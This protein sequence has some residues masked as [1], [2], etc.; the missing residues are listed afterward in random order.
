MPG[1]RWSGGLHQAIEAKEGVEVKPESI[2]LASITFQNLF[3]MYKKLAGMTGTALTSAEEFD[4]VY[5][6]DVVPI[7]TNKPIIRVDLSDRVY[8]TEAAKF[9]AVVSQ[10]K[11]C[12][13]KGQPVLVGTRSVE[14]NEYLSK[15]LAREGV[16]HEVLNAKNHEREGEI[17]A[18]AGSIG[19]VTIAT[20]M[21]GR[22]V[23]I[24]L[25][26]NPPDPQA[27]QKVR[28]AG[29]LF[30]IGTERH[31]ARRIDNQLRGRGGRQGDPGTTQFF[32]SLE[33]DLLRIFGGDQMK[34]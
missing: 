7:P 14:K 32:I 34:S 10:I 18:Q 24:L 1:R 26:G 16:K 4:K 19:A 2:T 13:S 6:L 12:L 27:A 29:G 23:D 22:G 21:A 15:L 8:K 17:I 31:E 9:N 11:N 28:E 3:R 25:G 33:D 30:I 20:N 5:G